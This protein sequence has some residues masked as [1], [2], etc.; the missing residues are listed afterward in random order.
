MKV[1]HEGGAFLVEK[2]MHNVQRPLC[3][4]YVASIRLDFH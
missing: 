2:Q 3:R 1:E 4:M